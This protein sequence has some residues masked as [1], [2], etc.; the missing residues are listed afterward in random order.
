MK[1]SPIKAALSDL[2][3]ELESARSA[4]RQIE[5]AHTGEISAYTSVWE[6]P[7]EAFC[8]V[9][10]NIYDTILVVLEAAEL[11]QTRQRV[12]DQ[13]VAFEKDG[14]MGKTRRHPEYDYLESKPFEYAER[15]INNLRILASKGLNPGHSYELAMLE[16]ILRRTPVLLKKRTV[17]P[18]SEQDIK[19]VMQDY[20]EAYFIEYKRTVNIPGVIRDFRPDG[21]VQKQLLNSSLSAH[22]RNYRGP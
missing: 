18:Q 17:H 6:A 19:V 15:A 2:E 14:G 20:L 1:T 8:W 10:N 13:L 11:H 22:S 21:G 16:T 7:E 4:R 3:Q 5:T 12:M 9:L